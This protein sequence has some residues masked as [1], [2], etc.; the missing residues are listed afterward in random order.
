[1]ESFSLDSL[2]EAMPLWINNQYVAAL[3]IVVVALI[4]A[5]I[6]DLLTKAAGAGGGSF[7]DRARAAINGT[8]VAR[9][10]K[11]GKA[12]R[13]ALANLAAE[14][15]YDPIGDVAIYA[16]CNAV[17]LDPAVL[18]DESTDE[19]ESNP[20]SP[21]DEIGPCAGLT[22]V[23][24]KNAGTHQ[25]YLTTEEIDCEG[26]AEPGETTLETTFSN[27]SMT[28]RDLVNNWE[29]VYQKVDGFEN[30]YERTAGE[31]HMKIT[32]FEDGH[33]QQSD[34]GELVCFLYTRT[35]IE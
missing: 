22:E 6:V 2:R 14:G 4:V 12:L 9:C 35:L 27:G 5:A 32:F 23:E 15:E 26:A 21:A 31:Y 1:M 30:V 24:C 13:D 33:V 29:Q 20:T 34:L 19:S 28:L 18:A 11:R 10:A 3:L 16:G 8:F 25:Y 17:K 7:R